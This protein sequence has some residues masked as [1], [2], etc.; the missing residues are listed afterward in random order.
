MRVCMLAYTFYESDTRILQY[1]AALRE[2][3]H[4]VDVIA[5]KRDASLPL[6]EPLN[7]VNVH[8][9]QV[10][11]VDERGLFSYAFRVVRFCFHA[12]SY[13][14]KM[15]SEHAYDL[16]HIHNVPDFLVFSALPLKM[17]RVPVI[18][19]IHD[20]LPELYASKFKA[21]RT[22]MLFK[23]LVLV[24][25]MSASLANHV[26]VAN[27]IWCRRLAQRSA[28]NEKCSVVRNR[29]DM[30]IFVAQRLRQR[31]VSGK[32]TMMYPGSL[33]DHQGLDV[34]VRAFAEIAKELADCEFHIYGEGSAKK[35]LIELTASFGLSNQ[36]FFH[37][38][39][40]SCEIAKIMASCD[41]A[42]EPKRTTSA[43]GNEALSTKI[44]E[45]MALGVPV[46]ACRT[47][48]HTHYYD[49][50]LIEYYSNDDHVELAQCMLRLRRDAERRAELVQNALQ[51][52]EVNTWDA[53]KYQYL[54]L[55]DKLC[56]S[57]ELDYNVTVG[58]Q[59]QNM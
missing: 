46:I 11:N 59:C 22:G 21:S 49:D 28:N 2:Q 13:L 25:R 14:R 7:G 19:D 42:I 31:S 39:L 4:I 30:K 15:H 5:L 18:L 37:N 54:D 27:D 50:S 43:F 44:M 55:V 29:P 52:V 34:A 20:L 48:I 32:F 23:L 17:D 41:L 1:T 9:I 16:V 6:F 38:P 58:D 47:K 24:E 12:A 53:K 36:I 26:I 10:R 51:Y 57:T 8:R 40:P 3:G 56:G 45:F 35:S 33:S